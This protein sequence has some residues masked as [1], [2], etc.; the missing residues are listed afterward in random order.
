MTP[1]A[2]V[3]DETANESD[4][5]ASDGVQG[6]HSGQQEGEHHQRCTALPGAV[7]VRDRDPGNADEKRNR[8]ENA[9]GLGETKAVSEPP[10]IASE[11][12]HV[13]K[14]RSDTLAPGR[15]G[16]LP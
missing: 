4:D 10:P 7:S 6:D 1:E 13:G 15:D 9:A 16:W 11:S 5:S 3:Q 8:E 2:A 14:P 12:R